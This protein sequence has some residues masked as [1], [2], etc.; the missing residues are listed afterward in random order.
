MPLDFYSNQN[1]EEYFFSLTHKQLEIFEDIFVEFN[2]RTG[3]FLDECRDAI[4]YTGNLQ[5]LL[6]IIENYVQKTDLNK[7]KNKTMEILSFYGLIR[8]YC[9]KNIELQVLGE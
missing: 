6:K 4:L 3:L 5:V 8:V 9:N 2:K 1:K 7:D